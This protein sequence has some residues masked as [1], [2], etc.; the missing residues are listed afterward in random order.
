[1]RLEKRFL[2]GADGAYVSAVLEM[3]NATLN[4]EVLG[5]SCNAYAC[6]EDEV[7]PI[8]IP[9]VGLEAVF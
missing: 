6:R 5:K 9:S 4:E 1:M 2:I 3:L 7:G 8:A